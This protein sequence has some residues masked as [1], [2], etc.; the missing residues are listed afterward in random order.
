M[1]RHGDGFIYLFAVNFLITFGFAAGDS[2]FSIY[3]QEK[4]AGGM[5]LGLAFTLYSLS[6]IGTGPLIGKLA[7]RFRADFI[8]FFAL[9]VYALIAVS[10]VF[11]QD[12]NLIVVMRILQGAACGMFRPVMVYL[13]NGIGENTDGKLFGRF[14]LAF[15]AALATAPLAGGLIAEHWGMSGVYI[16]VSFCCLTALFLFFLFSGL[17]SS[18]PKFCFKQTPQKSGRRHSVLLAYIFCR[19]W[20]I[21]SAAAF[22]PVYL[23]GIDASVSQTG[24][25]LCAASAVTAF[26][27][28]FT[29]S[30]ADSFRKETLVIVGGAASSF[31]LMLFPLVPSYQGLFVLSLAGGFFSAVSQPACSVLLISRTERAVL[32]VT[33]GRFNASMNAGFAAGPL[34]SSLCYTLWGVSSVF[35]VSGLLGAASSALFCLGGLGEDCRYSSVE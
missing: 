19:G 11:V 7:D 4:G 8:M 20:G 29:G 6:K 5:I 24:A 33:L 35:L 30:M 28:P 23:S 1:K 32:G 34:V 10:Y 3:F 26:M 9:A 21:A 14:D 27:L 17:H 31:I 16:L 15:Y 2:L 25:I 18:V 12:R 22:L 13:L